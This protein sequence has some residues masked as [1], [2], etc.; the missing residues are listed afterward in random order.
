MES[1]CWKINGSGGSA[2]VIASVRPAMQ[3]QHPAVAR[4]C[5]ILVLIY[6]FIHFY[7]FL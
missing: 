6:I 3:R 5:L 7:D 4:M 2:I 1:E